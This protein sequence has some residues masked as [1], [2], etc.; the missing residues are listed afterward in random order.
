MVSPL[1]RKGEGIDKAFICCPLPC[2]G[3]AVFVK[4]VRILVG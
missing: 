3:L 4:A 2:L 1:K